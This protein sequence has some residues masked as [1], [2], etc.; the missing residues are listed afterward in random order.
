MRITHRNTLE[1]R[2][3]TMTYTKHNPIITAMN[4]SFPVSKNAGA[5][6]VVHCPEAIS[7]KR[8][9]ELDKWTT[10]KT[11]YTDCPLGKADHRE[12]FHKA[13][14]FYNNDD[15]DDVPTIFSECVRHDTLRADLRKNILQL[16]QDKTH[17]SKP[18]QYFSSNLTRYGVWLITVLATID[19]QS[20][21]V[22]YI[23]T[24]LELAETT[25]RKCVTECVDA[26]YLIEHIL[27]TGQKGYMATGEVV[28]VYYTRMR[29]VFQLGTAPSIARQ[30][31]FHALI[32]YEDKFNN[33]FPKNKEGDH[34]DTNKKTK[35][36][37]LV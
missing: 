30:S 25:V 4:D 20:A 10:Q 34:T 8:A 17:N 35:V 23:S 31:V 9:L 22:S 16:K 26:K 6:E 37:N 14:M 24:T 1:P 19:N 12:S 18:L 36:V 27:P 28:N 29:R 5:T 21:T 32:A 11:T 7:L 2:R 13:K 33:T 15:P 3:K